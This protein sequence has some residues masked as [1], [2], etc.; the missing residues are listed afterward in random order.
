MAVVAV[1]IGVGLAVAKASVGSA[2]GLVA[3]SAAESQA[4][5]TLRRDYCEP[6]R[7]LEC[8]IGHCL[9]KGERGARLRQLRRGGIVREPAGRHLLPARA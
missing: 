7:C 6:R 4:L 5:L 9:L 8:A 1:Q 2:V 3:E